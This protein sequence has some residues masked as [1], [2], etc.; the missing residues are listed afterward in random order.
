M[1]HKHVISN[2][3]TIT[4]IKNLT[5]PELKSSTTCG[6]EEYVDKDT[7]KRLVNS[8]NRYL[9]PEEALDGE[10]RKRYVMVRNPKQAAKDKEHRG[11]VLDDLK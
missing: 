8:I 11:K 7:L 9:G 5:S 10:A 6:C 4:V 2:S 3:P 1:V